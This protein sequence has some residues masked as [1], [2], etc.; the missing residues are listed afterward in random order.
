MSS[1]AVLG[2]EKPRKKQKTTRRENKKKPCE[3][4]SELKEK[5]LLECGNESIIDNKLIDYRLICR[6]IVVVNN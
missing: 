5:I 2:G 1:G 6:L 3:E 4:G